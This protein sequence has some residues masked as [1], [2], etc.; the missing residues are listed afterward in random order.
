[1]KE[2]I[3]WAPLEGRKDGGISPT[4]AGPPAIPYSVYTERNRKTT[5]TEGTRDK[6]LRV[7]RDLRAGYCDPQRARET[8]LDLPGR[9][10]RR[11]IRLATIGGREDFIYVRTFYLL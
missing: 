9:G 4:S 5:S 8:M 3:I 6:K 7:H 2:P 1:M 11:R 10:L